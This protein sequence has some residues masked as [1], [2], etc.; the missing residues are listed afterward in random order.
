VCKNQFSFNQQ[1][2]KHEQ[3]SKAQF[4]IALLASSLRRMARKAQAKDNGKGP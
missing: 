3:N 1:P 4:E 2:S